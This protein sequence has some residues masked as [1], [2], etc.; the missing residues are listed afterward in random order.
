MP[1]DPLIPSSAVGHEIG[2]TPKKKRKERS[3]KGKSRE[4]DKT[5]QG[6]SMA[7]YLILED[8]K[9]LEAVSNK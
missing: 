7:H 5:Q 6:D 1:V 3:A 4:N 8:G 9:E 2:G